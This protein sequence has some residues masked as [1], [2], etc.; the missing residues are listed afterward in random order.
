MLVLVSGFQPPQLSMARF[1]RNGPLLKRAL[2]S[3]QVTS[4]PFYFMHVAFGFCYGSTKGTVFDERKQQSLLVTSIHVN[5]E[6]FTHEKAYIN[7]SI[8]LIYLLGFAGT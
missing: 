3:P 8:F 4:N 6:S 5:E 2:L 1:L 7:F